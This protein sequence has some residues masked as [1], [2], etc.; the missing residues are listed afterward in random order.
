MRD[1]AGC[2]GTAAGHITWV[3]GTTGLPGS[4]GT[5]NCLPTMCSA[6]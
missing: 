2:A 4:S 5:S 6:Y 1:V 3:G